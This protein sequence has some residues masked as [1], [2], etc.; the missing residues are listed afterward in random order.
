MGA[1]A[2]SALDAPAEGASAATALDP[3][4]LL[5]G[6]ATLRLLKH[7]SKH[8]STKQTQMVSF[9]ICT[10]MLFQVAAELLYQC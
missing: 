7:S 3:L 6:A 9:K 5:E 1:A 4:N 2:L 10:R 8:P